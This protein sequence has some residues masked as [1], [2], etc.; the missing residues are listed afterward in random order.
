MAGYLAEI[1]EE[2]H[3]LPDQQMGARRQRDTTTALK[4]LTEQIYTI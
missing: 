2:H 3:M 4:L 1:A